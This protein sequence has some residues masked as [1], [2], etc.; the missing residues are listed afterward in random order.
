VL[1]IVLETIAR[2]MAPILPFTADEIWQY[3]PAASGRESSI[4]LA[5]FP[6]ITSAFK[7]D[8][9]YKRWEFLLKIRGEATKALE[10]AR[11]KKLIGHPLDA[12]VTIS[13]K[14]EIYNALLP[15][16]DELR[17][18]LIVSRATLLKDEFLDGALE[19]DEI[20]G[21][22]IRVEPAPG[23][24]CE[25]CWVHDTSVGTNSEQATICERCQDALAMME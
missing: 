8:A 17:S 23:E 3:M 9:L 11:S 19:S 1:H 6:E 22:R 16:A 24:K 5:S 18:L 12:S 13:A 10:E 25:R 20:K 14:E 15:Y 21:V 4:H 7:D 2:L